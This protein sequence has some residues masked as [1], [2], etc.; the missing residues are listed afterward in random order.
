MQDGNRHFTCL[1]SRLLPPWAPAM[2]AMQDV[3]AS[4]NDTQLGRPGGYNVSF[5]PT[6]RGYGFDPQL[7]TTTNTSNWALLKKASWCAHGVDMQKGAVAAVCTTV[8]GHACLV[9]TA[10]RK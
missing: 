3:L 10:P 8:L 9:R 4:M 5:Q 6:N 7:G 1:T 2:H